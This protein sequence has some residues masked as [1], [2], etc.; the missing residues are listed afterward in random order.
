MEK[1]KQKIPLMDIYLA[2]YLVLHGITPHLAL[3]DTRVIFE[4]PGT[5]EVFKISREFNSNPLVPILD[6]VSSVRQLRSQMIALK[7]GV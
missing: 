6:F 5:D 7:R 3:Q 2:S 1:T 4:F